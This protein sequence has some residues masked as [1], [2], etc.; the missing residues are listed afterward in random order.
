MFAACFADR[1][2]L[3]LS[4]LPF[5]RGGPSDRGPH[6]M[7]RDEFVNATRAMRA[8]EVPDHGPRVFV[9]HGM[10]NPIVTFNGPDRATS[11]SMMHERMHRFSVSNDGEERV[12][13]TDFGGYYHCDVVNVDGRWKI[14]AV[15]MAV[16]FYDPETLFAF[17]TDRKRTTDH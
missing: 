3:D 4:G 14:C 13:F 10:M 12:E 17:N 16:T 5:G 1:V 15:R 8:P 9:Q 11:V 6:E 7:S 2:T